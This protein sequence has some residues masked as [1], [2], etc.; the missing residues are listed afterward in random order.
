MAEKDPAL[1]KQQPWQ[2]AYE[3]DFAWFSDTM[4]RHY[5]GDDSKVKVLLGGILK[6]F[7]AMTVG[8]FEKMAED[9][10][11][12]PNPEKSDKSFFEKVKD[13]FS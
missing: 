13:M 4:A 9:E 2:A 3:K 10:N 11:F 5:H 6:A 1:R 7:T 12:Q 8:T